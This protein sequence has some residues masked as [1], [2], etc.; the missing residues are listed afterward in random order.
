MRQRLRIILTCVVVATVALGGRLAWVQLVWGPDL[1][2]KA[3]TQRE[4]VYI[5]PARRGEILDRDGQRLA[6]TMKSRSLTVSPTR[7]RDELK[8]QAKMEAT[9]EGKLEG[10]DDNK[11]EEYLTKQ[12]EDKLK[13][14]SEG[15]PKMIEDSG[16]SASKV[17]ADDIKNK[18]KA[19]TQ[20]EV[21]VRNVDPDVAVEISNKYHGV[22]A[23]RQDIRQYPNGA[24]A[25]NV[26]GKVSMD[27]HG[28]FGFEAARD[29]ELTGIDGQST[30]DVST[31]GQVIPG[32]LRDVVDAVDGRDV[33]LT[34]DLDLQTYV[35]QK[36]EKAKANSQAEGAE[37]VVLDAA[38]G[39]VLAMANTD[40]VDPNKN[41]EDQLKEGKDFENRSISHPYEPGSVA[42]IVTAAA[43]LQEGITTPDEVHQV[44]GS[45][46]MAGVTVNDAWTHGTEPYTTTGIFGKSSNV[47]T[48]M[49][50][51]KLGP[52]KYAEYLKKFGLGANTGIELPN[53]S[54]G[55]VPD[56]EQ[57]SGGTFANLPIGQGQ[58]WTTLQMAS[59]YQAL[60][61]GGERIEPR[62]IDEI[63]DPDGETEKLPEPKKT[64]VVDKETAKTTV[65][66]FRAVF[67]D[68]DAGVQNGT[69]ANAQLDGYQ[70]SGKTGTAQKV[71][72]NSGAYSNSAYWITFAGIAPADD[73]RFVVAV[74]LDE[75]KSGVEDNGG[76][77]QSAAPI[78]RDI[79]SWLL[80]RDNIP[81]S[82]PAP[83]M[84]LREQ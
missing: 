75:P 53:E 31:D 28:Q 69:A 67:Q 77:G 15:I 54:A 70:L 33:T 61:N 22:A 64:Q 26:V 62:I 76:G 30:E 72:P 24:I 59:V 56:Q 84:T 83:R 82:T 3:V 40:T 68:D 60:A 49:I 38:T 21:L 80:N 81:T 71:D 6:Y 7:L 52:E 51:D 25:E 2:A 44:P 27:G 13:E 16:A 47:G 63:K 43:A 9:S 78:F 74:M 1:A 4:R 42:K 23:D 46:D 37:A 57:W 18:L 12:M 45:I 14:M 41:I 66:M 19:D 34:L 17:D 35:Q 32:T 11:K 79:S 73:P 58:A 65:D 29:T 5:D 48:L 39:Q 50:A 20:Y 55:T 8:E 36:L 10:M